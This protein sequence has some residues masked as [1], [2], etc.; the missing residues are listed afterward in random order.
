MIINNHDLKSFSRAKC[1]GVIADAHESSF[2]IPKR[3]YIKTEIIERAPPGEKIVKILR[4]PT[5]VKNSHDH[6]P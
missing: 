4:L 2:R 3:A 1:G 6:I 5:I